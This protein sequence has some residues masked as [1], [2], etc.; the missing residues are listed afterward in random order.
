MI[1]FARLTIFHRTPLYICWAAVFVDADVFGDLFSWLSG[2]IAESVWT[3]ERGLICVCNICRY[4]TDGSDIRKLY[5]C[6]GVRAIRV[7]VKIV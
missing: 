1:M 6:V 5:L 3:C 4:D 7:C 2:R